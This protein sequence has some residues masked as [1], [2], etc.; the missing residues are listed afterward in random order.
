M[1]GVGWLES[2]WVVKEIEGVGGW[3]IW[4]G[5]M[6]RAG[7]GERGWGVGVGGLGCERLRD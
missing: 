6:W 2:G 3:S 5:F 7:S 1:N 4:F